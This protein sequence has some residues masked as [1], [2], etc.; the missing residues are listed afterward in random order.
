MK[1]CRIAKA[2]EINDET[3]VYVPLSDHK[4]AEECERAA[5]KFDGS[6]NMTFVAIRINT[7]FRV[8]KTIIETIQKLIKPESKK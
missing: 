2:S 8:I 7:P 5:K 6:E 3:E 4:S 1:L